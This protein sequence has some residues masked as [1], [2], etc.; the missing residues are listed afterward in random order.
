MRCNRQI[1]LRSTG[2]LG[3]QMFQ[4]TA[5]R[6]AALQNAALSQSGTQGRSAPAGAAATGSADAERVSAPQGAASEA[7]PIYMELGGSFR[8]DWLA[9]FSAPHFLCEK[10]RRTPAQLFLRSALHFV[11]YTLLR[12]SVVKIQRLQKPLQP[13]LNRLGLYYYSYGY[14]PFGPARAE[15]I[16]VEGYFETPRYADAIREVILQD[17]TPVHLPLRENEALYAA[18]QATNSVCVSV[19]RGDFV[20]G[21]N[22][23]DA[24]DCN[25]CTPD[26]FCRAAAL[27]CERLENPVFFVFSDDIAWAREHLHFDGCEMHYERGGDPVWEK[28]RLMYHCKHFILSNSTFSWWAQYLSRQPKAE[29]LVIAPSRWRNQS[30]NNE[31]YEDGWILLSPDEQASDA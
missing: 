2:N 15:N 10:S 9:D 3:N 13:L 7:L 14:Y 17:F 6:W 27:C 23:A 11:R 1:S 21:A 29:K 5:A 19:R 30:I 28:L 25:V 18:I 22:K 16:V 20:T 26:Y 8:T 31:I 24:E 4:Y 12:Q